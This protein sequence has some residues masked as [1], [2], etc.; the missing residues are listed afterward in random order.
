[1]STTLP[2]QDTTVVQPELPA[3]DGAAIPRRRLHP[4]RQAIP[5][6][7]LALG[8]LAWWGVETWRAQQ[9]SGSLTVSGTV[10]ADEVLVAPEVPG[11][12]L[13][14]SVREGQR[15]AAGDALARLDDALAQLQ[16]V[17]AAEP[18]ARRQLE[19]QAAKY[20]LRAP[21]S[22]VVTRIPMRPGEVIG[23]GQTALAVADLSELKLI[24]YVPEAKLGSVRLGQRLNVT[25]DPFPDRLFEGR[26][27]SINQRAEFTP[28]NVQTQRDRLNLVFGVN[29]RV[30]NP[31]G[32]LK[33]GMP[34]DAT[35][36]E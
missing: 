27:T 8:A 24:V 21:L 28:R 11:R 6:V 33:P 15:V 17:Q 22:G 10:E 4:P 13:E 18:A 30:R 7:L 2:A 14:I 3:P 34:V 26:I 31:D 35:F 25:A 32:A 19:L 29:A 36:I 23:A 16:V 5:L 9:P 1:M 20:V 12:L